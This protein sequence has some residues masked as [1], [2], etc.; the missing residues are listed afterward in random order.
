M[1]DTAQTSIIR[2]LAR[3]R[4]GSASALIQLL[5]SQR[6]WLKR[7]V[8]G[9]L[10]RAMAAR[11]DDTDL[12]REGIRIAA[13]RFPS[14]RGERVQSFRA[15]LRRILTHHIQRWLRYWNQAKRDRRREV[16]LGPGSE[17][18]SC[19]AAP[20]ECNEREVL[21]RALEVLGA[22]DRCLLEL[23]LSQGLPLAEGATRLG[24]SEAAA[25]Q[26]F[27]R[28][29]GRLREIID[30]IVL[31]DGRGAIPEKVHVLTLWRF[32]AMTPEEIASRL[33]LPP[34]AIAHWVEE[35]RGAVRQGMGEGP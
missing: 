28:A 6:P 11:Q 17:P 12:V 4:E 30:W 18:V 10:P 14:F 31:W 35:A 20:D 5:E 8:V 16:N 15:W 23:K 13:R 22:E 29:L 3:A 34:E 7:V 33:G 1:A 21:Q 27:H 9:G 32:Q 24:I 26:R 25:R 2:L 19:Q